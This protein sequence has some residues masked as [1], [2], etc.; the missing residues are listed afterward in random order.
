M[1]ISK[2]LCKECKN[3]NTHYRY[4]LCN[5]CL[6]EM[7][8]KKLYGLCASFSSPWKYNN[9]L[10]KLY[11]TYQK[12]CKI[13]T[14]IIKRTKILIDILE[15]MPV[16]KFF[17][18]IDIYEFSD[19]LSIGESQDNP[20]QKCPFYLIGRL[21]E[22]AGGIE[23]EYKVYPIFLCYRI[24]QI[25]FQPIIKR[26][27]T[28]VLKAEHHID[29]AIWH[30]RIIRDFAIFKQVDLLNI[31]NK[32]IINYLNHLAENTDIL[33]FKERISVIRKFYDWLVNEKNLSNNPFIPLDYS[34]L[35]GMCS[36]CNKLKIIT[37]KTTHCSFCTND[38]KI[39]NYI[40]SFKIK[41]TKDE[42]YSKYLFE[43]YLIYI[44]RFRVIYSSWVESKQLI[45]ILKSGQVDSLLSWEDV[46]KAS[47]LYKKSY[48]KRILKGCP[49]IKIGN[50]LVEIGV[51]P[52]RALDEE[53][54][55]GRGLARLSS[56]LK[57]IVTEYCHSLV[58]R[59]RKVI[60]AHQVV[61]RI[62]YFEKWLILNYPEAEFFNVEINIIQFY[63]AQ[64][65]S[66]SRMAHQLALRRFF[67]W[68]CFNKICDKNPF[69]L[70]GVSRLQSHLTICSNEQI[71][72]LIKYLKASK[73]DP[74]LSI[75]IA[76]SLFWGFGSKELIFSNFKIN[77][78]QIEIHV[79]QRSLSYAHKSAN[80]SKVF[81]IPQ[82]PKWFFELQQRYIENWNLK[83]SH[84][85]WPSELR[86]LFPPPR[87]VFN[88]PLDKTVLNEYI[89]QATKTATGK[90]IPIKILRYTSGHL[91]VRGLD[92]SLLTQ[93]GWSSAS[94]FRYTWVPRKLH[95]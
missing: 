60:T 74:S 89:A 87:G 51:I 21:L 90:S 50:M 19:F 32:K 82:R 92:G 85:H 95:S 1:R 27:M 26:Y 56:L 33:E 14:E 35:K 4:S 93:L 13:N 7:R 64:T 52:P 67:R 40:A 79:F 23:K 71:N 94:A 48:G 18:W 5:G 28:D 30:L 41:F 2:K 17:N 16:P 6:N 31:N 12:R 54:K 57:P 53:L 63:L 72:S 81:I 37:K 34:G 59:K 15:S 86:P 88:R 36:R 38:I 83:F 8:T 78:N 58:K 44:K 45:L 77:N 66:G 20:R 46:T 47:L 25:E 55:L 42:E 65:K 24:F 3:H 43:L 68:C 29:V 22:E 73:N 11:S 75:M 84:L 39:F 61:L 62:L 10:F 49:F 9:Y 91:N 70:L 80:R 76:L 69:E